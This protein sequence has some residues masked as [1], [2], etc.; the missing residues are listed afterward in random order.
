MQG[1]VIT[2]LSS[3][4][5]LET[6]VL[7][8]KPTTLQRCCFASQAIIHLHLSKRKLTIKYFL[9]PWL[10]EDRFLLTAFLTYLRYL[11]VHVYN[12]M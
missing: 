1:C 3:L 11:F 4:K 7:V 2:N 9:Y 5:A 6:Y 8:L 10:Q 12:F